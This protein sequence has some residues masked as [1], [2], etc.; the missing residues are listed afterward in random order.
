MSLKITV[1]VGEI[2]NLSDA[3]YCAGMGVEMLGFCLDTDSKRYVSPKKLE[4]IGGWVAGVKL[5]GEITE[6]D[7]GHLSAYPLDGLQV[8]ASR[9]EA[10]IGSEWPLIALYPIREAGDWLQAEAFMQKYQAHVEYFL[11]QIENS[12]SFDEM[13]NLGK[14]YP[15]LLEGDFSKNSIHQII[16]QSQAKGI[17]LKGGSEISA[18]LKDYDE[19]AEI[20]EAIE[21]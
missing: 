17:A 13:P 10:F 11:L 7:F 3:R 4:Q 5:I 12:L 1:K 15:I 18:G 19:L 8:L 2:D 14:A 16:E 6:P 9:I 21:V 20:L